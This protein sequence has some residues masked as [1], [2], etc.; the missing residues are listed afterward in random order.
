MKVYGKGG[1]GGGGVLDQYLG[2]GVACL[3]F[4]TMTLGKKFLKFILGL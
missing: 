4:E 3:G 1:R 2:I